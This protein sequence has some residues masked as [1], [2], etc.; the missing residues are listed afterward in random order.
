MGA[1]EKALSFRRK[2]LNIQE[3]VQCNPLQCATTYIYFG[4]I[5]REM[6][7]YLIASTNFIKALGILE[8]KLPKNH[9]DLAVVYHNMAK[10]YL[11]TR[12]YSIAMK[13][14]QQALE[15]AQEKLLTNHPHYLDYRETF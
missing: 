6:E 9:P 7:D 2:A 4:E 12:Q 3:N 13:N 15:I 10:L 8:S 14:V 1:Y 11:A 5:Y